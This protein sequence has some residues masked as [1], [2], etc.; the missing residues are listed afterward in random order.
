MSV[1]GHS[2]DMLEAL[3]TTDSSGDNLLHIYVTCSSR[4]LDYNSRHNN[5]SSYL[6]YRDLL[7]RVLFSLFKAV[8]IWV[9]LKVR[10]WIL[11]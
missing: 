3:C 6:S 1:C 7:F 11:L 8:W 4:T 9:T 5:T 10:S 2:I